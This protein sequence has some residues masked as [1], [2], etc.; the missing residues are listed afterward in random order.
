M[1]ESYIPL[2]KVPLRRPAPLSDLKPLQPLPLFLL[3]CYLQVPVDDD[4]SLLNQRLP[5]PHD[6][7][8]LPQLSLSLQLVPPPPPHPLGG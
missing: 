8:P 5:P 2:T 4:L 6:A 1:P 3:L 7:F